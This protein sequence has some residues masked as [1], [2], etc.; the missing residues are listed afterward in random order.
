MPLRRRHHVLGAIVDELY[1][2]SGFP[3]QQR[4]VARDDRRILF[5]AAKA[6]TGLHLHDTDLVG[7]QIEERTQRLV[8][9]VRALHR[10]PDRD[11]RVRARSRD[12]AVRF[13]VELFLRPG[14]VLA[15]DDDLRRGKC[16]VDVA[17]R[18]DVLLEDV[19][20]APHDRSL[21]ERFIDR[22]DGRFGLDVDRDVTTRPLEHLT[23]GMS[24]QQHG[25]F[26]MIDAI[27]RQARL[28][29]ED[30]SD[31]VGAG[32]VARR[33]DDE[34]RPRD[35]RI[36]GYPFDESA[37]SAAANRGAVEHP[38]QREIIDVLRRAGD[39]RASFPPRHGLTQQHGKRPL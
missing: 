27:A 36:E 38:R 33:D 34:F 23:I 8:N 31:A 22:E 15:F 11:A 5:L 13:D 39:L 6:A 24:Q 35:D 3:R 19:V 30:Q 26:R 9:V 12:H 7:G 17:A 14:L 28:V 1:G 2:R 29:V 10:S 16:R 20:G 37:W 18:D 21:F 4:R 25:L 32:N